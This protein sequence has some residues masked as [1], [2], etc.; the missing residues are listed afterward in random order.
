MVAQISGALLILCLVPVSWYQAQK[1]K[2]DNQR[3]LWLSLSLASITASFF[4]F[5]EQHSTEFAVFFVLFHC[6]WLAWLVIARLARVKI[7]SR[8]T[9]F[10]SQAPKGKSTLYKAT[11][12][13]LS[14]TLAFVASVLVSQ[15]V[16]QL[17]FSKLANQWA[18]T[19]MAAPLIWGAAVT[20]LASDRLI[21]RPITVMVVLTLL[22]WWYLS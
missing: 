18:V 15:A 19:L 16:A 21:I 5:K 10:V 4:L 14:A 6:S 12:F 7:N 20:W 13:M 11:V 2:G 22:S 3:W 17:L 9:T 1:H 8:K